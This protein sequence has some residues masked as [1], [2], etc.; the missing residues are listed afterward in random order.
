M[1]KNNFKSCLSD[2]ERHLANIVFGEAGTV[3]VDQTPCGKANINP[4]TGFAYTDL[5]KVMIQQDLNERRRLLDNLPS[6][7]AEFLDDKISDEDALRFMQ[8]SN[9]QLPS[10][11]ANEVERRLG[12]ELKRRESMRQVEERQELLDFIA[13]ERKESKEE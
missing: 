12:E 5:Q 10:E 4:R 3:A 13:G 2:N 11:F 1:D 6:F 7:R 8:P 9:M